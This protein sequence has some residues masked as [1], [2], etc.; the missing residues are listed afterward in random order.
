MIGLQPTTTE[1]R[2]AA[3]LAIQTLRAL[4]RND[5]DSGKDAS[6]LLYAYFGRFD[7]MED[8][9]WLMF[10]TAAGVLDVIF[11]NTQADGQAI[12]QFVAERVLTSTPNPSF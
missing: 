5:P 11:S 8:A 2:D 4:L 3:A 6:D 12:L 9:A 1:E 7:N 10:N